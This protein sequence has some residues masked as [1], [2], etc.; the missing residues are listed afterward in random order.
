[1]CRTLVLDD[2]LD[3][4]RF[5]SNRLAFRAA[6]QSNLVFD[7]AL[8]GDRALMGESVLETAGEGGSFKLGKHCAPVAGADMG[9]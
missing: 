6:S 3:A 9:S 2:C 5:I 4:C 8:Y 7:R 1:M